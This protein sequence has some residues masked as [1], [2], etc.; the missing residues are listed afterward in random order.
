MH[1]P[2]PIWSGYGSKRGPKWG[3]K[4][5]NLGE[6]V[7]LENEN[8]RFNPFIWTVRPFG[9]TYFRTLNRTTYGP[10]MGASLD[11]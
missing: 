4:T 8:V 5:Q 1:V 9:G 7:T 2:P 3:S 6:S 10:W 11:V